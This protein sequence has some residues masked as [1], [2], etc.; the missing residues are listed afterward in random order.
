M[1]E[2][3]TFTDIVALRAQLLDW[4]DAGLRIG[5]VP[6]MGNLHAG[7]LRLVERALASSDRVIVSVFVNPLQFGPNEDYDSYPRTLAED[8]DKL[9]R[10]GA[11]ALFAPPVNEVY[12]TDLNHTTRVEVPGI[13]DELCGHFRP[14]FFVGITTVVAKLFNMIQPDLAVFGEKDYQQLAII[15]RMVDELSFPVEIIGV[16]IVRE[17]DGL[18]MSSRN[19]YLSEEERRQAP[20][21][22][23]ALTT[24]AET[25]RAGEGNFQA[26]QQQVVETLTEAGFRVDYVEVRQAHTLAPAQ[27]GDRALVILAAAWLGPKTRLIDNIQVLT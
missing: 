8:R 14:G 12:G 22:Y 11:Q 19:A 26:V 3:Q 27:S 23:A 21:L 18:A 9:Q 24:A 4:R 20:R 2:L 16:P 25:L 17:T 15:R 7:H 13:S 1:S 6:T 10:V 5:F